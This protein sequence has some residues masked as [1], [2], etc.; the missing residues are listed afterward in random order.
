MLVHALIKE[1]RQVARDIFLMSLSAPEVA[2]SARAGQFIH[3]RCTKGLDPLLRRP[4]SLS[5]I[6]R[7]A[8]TVSLIYEV[9]GRGTRILSDYLVGQQVDLLGPLGKGFAIEHLT[10]EHQ[11]VLV[12]GGIGAP[13]MAALGQ[14]LCDHGVKSVTTILGA[15][16]KD[17]LLPEEIFQVNGS[18]VLVATDDGSQGHQGLVTDLLPPLVGEG[19]E[20]CEVFAC[21]PKGM[22]K[23]VGD[24]CLQQGIP[25]QLSL[26]EVMACGVGACQ[27]CACR[28][29]LGAGFNYARVCTE[30]PVFRAEEVVWDG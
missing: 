9:R 12:G 3:I 18:T 22:L 13:P 23:A 20:T 26:E 10:S 4:F 21:G 15:A 17:K 30:G 19:A 5:S 14:A 6:D 11:A 25:C 7:Q 24:Y 27:G 8:G 1:H 2:A 16:S 28:I 29:K